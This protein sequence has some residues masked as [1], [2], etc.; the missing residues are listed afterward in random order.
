[1]IAPPVTPHGSVVSHPTGTASASWSSGYVTQCT[2]VALVWAGRTLNSKL[3]DIDLC[4]NQA[5]QAVVSTNGAP[6]LT[7]LDCPFQETSTIAWNS[8][9]GTGKMIFVRWGFSAAF[10][11]RYASKGGANCVRNKRTALDSHNV[12]TASAS[13]S[14]SPSTALGLQSSPNFPTA[15]HQFTFT[16]QR[17]SYRI[18]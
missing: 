14:P 10:P 3:T 4:N 12:W 6:D 16:Y 8:A 5:S 15:T 2:G 7:V 18:W 1:L 9:S 17:L 11:V 13:R